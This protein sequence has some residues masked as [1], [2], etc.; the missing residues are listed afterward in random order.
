[1]NNTPFAKPIK[2]EYVPGTSWMYVAENGRFGGYET[3]SDAIL[4]GTSARNG[5]SNVGMQVQI[6]TQDGTTLAKT[7]KRV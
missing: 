1:M 5:W 2:A 4:A 7:K 3:E 6:V